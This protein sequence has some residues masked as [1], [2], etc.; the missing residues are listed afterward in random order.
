MIKYIKPHFYFGRQGLDIVN[1]SC[2]SAGI[3]MPASSALGESYF[4]SVG[5]LVVIIN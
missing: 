2:F 4:R 3:K 5:V 1:K